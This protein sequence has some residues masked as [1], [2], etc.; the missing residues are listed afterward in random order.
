M[1]VHFVKKFFVNESIKRRFSTH[2]SICRRKPPANMI[3]AFWT[4]GNC[5]IKSEKECVR[6]YPL[7]GQEDICFGHSHQ[8]K[9]ISARIYEL[10]HDNSMFKGKGFISHSCIG[11]K[12]D[13]CYKVLSWFAPCLLTVP[14]EYL[15]NDP[16]TLYFLSKLCNKSKY[17]HFEIQVHWPPT[18][19][20]K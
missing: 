11:T 10:L 1:S 15:S 12:F 5:P 14:I 8:F 13:S 3:F 19:D 6:R 4:Y 18:G 7:A 17:R 9:M 16:K 20:I 2:R